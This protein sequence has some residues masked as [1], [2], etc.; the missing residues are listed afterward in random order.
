MQSLKKYNKGIKTLL[1]VIDLF[2]KYAWVVPFK[3]KRGI[4]IVNASQKI[5]SKEKKPNKIWVDQ[6]GEIYN[7]LF[8]RFLKIN[9]I[10]VYS[11]YNEGKSVVAERFNR[12]LKSKIFKHMKAVLKNVY[13]D[14]LDDIINKY[15]STIHRTIKMKPIDFT[16]DSY[17][18]Y[19]EDSNEKDP[20]FKVSDRVKYENT[21][22]FLLKDTPKVGQKKFLLLVK[23]KTQFCGL[24]LLMT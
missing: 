14:V 8:K 6:G 11:T 13:F 4:T 10:E 23:L 1:C 16:S 12:T 18:E 21:K 3:G 7:Q 9:N 24:M 2:S 17:A 5:I 19:N 15:N 20:K 22:T